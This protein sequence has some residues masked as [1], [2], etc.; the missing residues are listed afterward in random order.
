MTEL[1]LV[2]AGS[3]LAMAATLL[4]LLYRQPAFHTNK[5]PVQEEKIRKE[6]MKAEVL[7]ERRRII[8]SLEHERNSKVITLIHRKEPWANEGDADYIKIEDSEHILREIRNTAS[9]KPIDIIIHTPGGLALAAEMIAA[10]LSKHKA[11][12]TAIVPFYAMSGGTL[13]ALS[14]DKIIMEEFSVLG[15]VDP[16]IGGLPSGALMNVLR[17]KKIEQVSDQ[18]IIMSEIAELATRQMKGF[19]KS[20]LTDKIQGERREK[21]AELFTGGYVTHDTPI[22]AA[23]AKEMGLSVKV[24]VPDKVYDLFLTCEHGV[25]ERPSLSYGKSIPVT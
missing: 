3:I 8:E 24:G 7:Q 4:A 14:A 17:R 23:L 9:D 12:V 16:Q 2:L 13:I 19:V 20:L 15:P 10:A 25:C 1:E 11:K 21:L 18:T 22:T 5:D 6:E